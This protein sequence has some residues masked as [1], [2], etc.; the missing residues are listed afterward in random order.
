[1]SNQSNSLLV[2]EVCS[3]GLPEGGHNPLGM[4][5]FEC[6]SFWEGYIWQS[7][8]LSE[9]VIQTLK[10]DSLRFL[11]NIFVFLIGREVA[12]TTYSL[13][14]W[15]S[16]IC[17][18]LPKACL[19][20]LLNCVPEHQ[21]LWSILSHAQK[22]WSNQHEEKKIETAKHQNRT[23]KGA[24]LSEKQG[25]PVPLRTHQRREPQLQELQEVRGE[26]HILKRWE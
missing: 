9:H 11:H 15:F 13:V 12:V 7:P 23:N 24:F 17:M 8:C 25:A 1:M 4:S 22:H 6:A 3:H 2:F 20:S 10:I 21:R 16:M 14:P 26:A 19:F 5:Q 18:R